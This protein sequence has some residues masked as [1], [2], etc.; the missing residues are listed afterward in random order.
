MGK[1]GIRIMLVIAMAS[2]VMVAMG[3]YRMLSQGQTQT[4]TQVETVN[5][6]IAREDMQRGTVLTESEMD[7]VSGP[8]TEMR[9]PI[10]SFDF[11]SEISGRILK[12]EIK[13]GET[14]LGGMLA[15]KGDG[16]PLGVMVPP[17]MRGVIVHVDP[18][19]NVEE[20]LRVGDRVDVVLTLD[21]DT[22]QVSSSKILLQDTQVLGVPT[23]KDEV[24]PRRSS[25]EWVPVALAVSPADAEKLA[26]ANNIGTVQ[27][28][29][30]GYD[31]ETAVWTSGVTTDT[32]I[33]Q[34]AADSARQVPINSESKRALRT[35]EVIKGNDRTEE[36]FKT[37]PASNS[38]G[39]LGGV[40]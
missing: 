33:P 10:G 31:D 26:L 2:G 39:Y 8:V 40:R 22:T 36:R 9:K 7:V 11:P 1:N 4:T 13:K 3:L 17:G 30:R 23:A 16:I 29:V 21:N 18:E 14:I 20:F 24:D 34:G 28:I 32:I 5:I 19:S 6:V 35:V 25:S 27:L 15:P 12:T 38:V 37:Q